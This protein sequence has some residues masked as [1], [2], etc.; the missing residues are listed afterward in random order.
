M[1]QQI[2]VVCYHRRFIKKQ[3][4]MFQEYM[5]QLISTPIII[6]IPRKPCGRRLYDEVWAIASN[7]L[8]PNSKFQ[9]PSMRWWERKDWKTFVKRDE[10]IYKPFVLK[11]VDRM[12]YACSQ[13]HWTDKCSGCLIEPTDAPIFLEDLINNS[14][15]AIEWNSQLLME[16]YN[17]TANEVVEHASTLER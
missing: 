1:S 15:L 2:F 6:C 16:N 3:E 8:K 17:Q 10:G 7:L 4:V 5:P 9:R 14:F 11:M 12:G 13:C